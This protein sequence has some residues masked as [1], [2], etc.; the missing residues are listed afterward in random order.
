MVLAMK[1]HITCGK[2]K[3]PRTAVLLSVT[4][5]SNH[6]DKRQAIQ[7]DKRMQAASIIAEARMEYGRQNDI[8]TERKGIKK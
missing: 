2:V 8:W 6:Q 5:T 1:V 7:V 4:K 3:S